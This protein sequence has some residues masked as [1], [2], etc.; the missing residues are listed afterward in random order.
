MAGLTEHLSMLP[1][2][3]IK[4]HYQA[5]RRANLFSILA[6]ILEGPGLRGFYA[7]SSVLAL[8]CVPAHGIYFSLY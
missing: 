5:N 6:R 8:G 7:G 2:D 1:L 4:T 3:N